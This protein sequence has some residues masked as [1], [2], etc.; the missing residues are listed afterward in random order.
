M[1]IRKVAHGQMVEVLTLAKKKDRFSLNGLQEYVPRHIQG[2][3]HEMDH[4]K[5]RELNNV[6]TICNEL[7]G[8]H[9]MMS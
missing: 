7:R 9:G 6:D 1:E 8:L 3:Y 2:T 5:E 4:L